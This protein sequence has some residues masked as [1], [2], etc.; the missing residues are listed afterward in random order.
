MLWIKDVQ[1]FNAISSHAF[2]L[3]IVLAKLW[4][5][6]NLDFPEIRGFPETL[7]YLLGE[8]GRGNRSR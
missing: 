3:S 5:F 7:P 8:I 1:L 6:T 4:Y 2:T